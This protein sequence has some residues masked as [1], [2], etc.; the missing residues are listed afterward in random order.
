[1]TDHILIVDDEPLVRSTLAE[2]LAR[3]R[4][5]VSEAASGP[6]ALALLG[7][8][9]HALI[10]CDIRMPEMDGMEL[11]AEVR[12]SHPGVD[13][14]LMTGFASID[15]AIDALS[16][17][18]ADYLTKPLKPKEVVARVRAVLQ[19]RRM[20]SELESLHSELRARYDV[21]NLVAASPRMR[22]LLAAIQRIKDD[23]E[24][25]L[26]HGEIGSGRRYIARTIHYA[27]SRRAAPFACVDCRSAP[28]QRLELELFGDAQATR[29]KLGA[30]DSTRGGSVHIAGLEH[31]APSL[32]V[33]LARCVAEGTWRTGGSGP[34]APLETRLLFSIDAPLSELLGSG[35]LEPALIVLSHATTLHVPPLRQRQEDLSGLIATFFAEDS[36]EHGRSGRLGPG[37]A[38]LLA[39]PQ[40]PGNV[41]QLFAI[42]SHCSA[43]S[44]DGVLSAENL[45]RSLNQSHLG[46]DRPIAEHL[47]DRE[48]QLVLK[49]VHR[50]PRRLDQAARELGVSRTTLWRRMR[51]YGIKLAVPALTS[52]H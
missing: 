10:L 6:E 22:A 19:R 2:V 39:L 12:R 50:N 26:L 40:Y 43:L 52:E 13:V 17:G 7:R 27:S 30:F 8:E 36:R 1:M 45:V 51:K 46:A 5:A 47:G 24:M 21:R 38:E 48:F 42:L 9:P 41:A 29:R 35:R 20:E 23:S 44:V 33:E 11:L 49:A 32:Q 16:L 37:A 18:A 28:R 31:A 4:H 34:S 25:V 3:E 14:V 15:G